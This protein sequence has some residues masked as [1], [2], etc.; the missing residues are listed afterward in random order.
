MRL[1]VLN[2]SSAGNCYIVF[3]EEEA[4]IIEAGV[5]FRCV[6]DVLDFNIERIRGV[7][8]SHAHL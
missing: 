7:V 8:I 3:N 4:L 2:S 1:N 5:S 6:L